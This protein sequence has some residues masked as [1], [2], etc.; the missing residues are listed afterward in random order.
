MT[1]GIISIFFF[2]FRFRIAFEKI[3][4]VEFDK[5]QTTHTNYHTKLSIRHELKIIDKQAITEYL[6]N[7]IK[8]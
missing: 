5:L 4:D 2:N 3:C 8:D 6:S 1:L 7:L